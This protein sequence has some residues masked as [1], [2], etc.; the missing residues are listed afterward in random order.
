MLPITPLV[1]VLCQFSG[2]KIAYPNLAFNPYSLT[3]LVPMSANCRPPSYHTFF[4]ISLFT[5]YHK[6]NSSVHVSGVF[7]AMPILAFHTADFLSN[8]I[9]GACYGTTSGSFFISL[10]LIIL[11]CSRSIP[12]VHASLYSLLELDWSNRPGTCV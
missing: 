8:I 9:I 6:V 7:G 4:Q 2:L 10:L 5:I 1:Q 11:E 12:V 3:F